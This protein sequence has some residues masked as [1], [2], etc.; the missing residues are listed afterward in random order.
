M[1]ERADEIE[2]IDI[3]PEELMIRLQAGKVYLPTQAERALASFFQKGN[4]VALRELSL[5]QAAH[6][7]HQDVEAAREARADLVPWATTE[8][9]LVSVGPSPSSAKIIRTTKRMAAALGADWLA[10]AVNTGSEGRN[11]AA[12]RELISRN[13]QLAEELGAETHVVIGRNVADA[14][15]SYALSRNVTKLIAGK[16]AQPWWKRLVRRTV[17]EELLERSGDID[18]YVITGE[19]GDTPRRDAAITKRQAC[20]GGNMPRRPQSLRCAAAW[21]S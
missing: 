13:L 12:R 19:G 6:R 15:L 20:L 10:V 14:L 17:V 1:L 2:L 8:R 4:L 3:T 21:L 11:A 9:L 16:T 18:V 7:L 5:R